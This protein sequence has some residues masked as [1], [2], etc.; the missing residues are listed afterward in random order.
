MCA[1][2]YS[3]QCPDDSDTINDECLE[4]EGQNLRNEGTACNDCDPK[5]DC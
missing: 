3:L 2:A 4:C 1:N 5:L